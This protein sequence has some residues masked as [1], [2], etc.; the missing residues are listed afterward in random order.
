MRIQAFNTILS[1]RS[2]GSNR[3][4]KPVDTSQGNGDP[5]PTAAGARGLPP[6]REPGPELQVRAQP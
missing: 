1:P 5:G 3:E 4:Q 2:I 6:P